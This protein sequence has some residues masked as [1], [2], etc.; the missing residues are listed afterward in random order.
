MMV[1]IFVFVM[2]VLQPHYARTYFNVINGCETKY[3]RRTC[4]I[5]HSKISS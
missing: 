2:G 1:G 3:Q 4:I 5:P